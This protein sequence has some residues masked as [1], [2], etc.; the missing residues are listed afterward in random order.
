MNIPPIPIYSMWSVN[1]CNR[2]KFCIAM[3][4]YQQLLNFWSYD[5]YLL[6]LPDWKSAQEMLRFTF[7]E[8]F[9]LNELLVSIES[10]DH[11]CYK[12]P[13]WLQYLAH[14]PLHKTK[15]FPFSRGF[16]S[17]SGFGTRVTLPETNSSH[18]KM[19]GW[20]TSFLLEWPIFRGYV[21]FRE[22][23]TP[24]IFLNK[25]SGADPIE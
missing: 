24:R 21:S 1:P 3:R 11:L 16:Q 15:T 22:G 20:N 23:R 6:K 2:D 5:S 10:I 12:H 9:T 17:F 14:P 19:D 18:L 7:T 8:S 4:L 25:R 13:T